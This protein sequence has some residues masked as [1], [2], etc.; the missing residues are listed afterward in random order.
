MPSACTCYSLP[1]RLDALDQNHFIRQTS[2]QSNRVVAL[3]L[4]GGGD[5]RRPGEAAV[6]PLQHCAVRE[7]HAVDAGAAPLA[8]IP[9]ACR[10]VQN[11]CLVPISEYQIFKGVTFIP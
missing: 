4:A 9:A 7:P 5:R 6:R 8:G 1:C 11:L 10:A 2:K 3:Q